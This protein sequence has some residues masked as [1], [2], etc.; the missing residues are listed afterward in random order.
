MSLSIV[1]ILHAITKKQN[2]KKTRRHYS[3]AGFLLRSISVSALCQRCERVLAQ[4]DFTWSSL[5]LHPYP[6]SFTPSLSHSLHSSQP[7][8]IHSISFSPFP[9][10]QSP[11][12]FAFSL[13]S[14]SFICLIFCHFKFRIPSLLITS[15]LNCSLISS[16]MTPSMESR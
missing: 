11:S 6:L 2:R 3:L 9:V 15:C 5:H 7:S 10:R 13:P 1:S 8:F 16:L 14:E 4:D 12:P